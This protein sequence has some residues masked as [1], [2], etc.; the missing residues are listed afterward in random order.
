[1]QYHAGDEEDRKEAKVK[2]MFSKR[3]V[4]SDELNIAF[5]HFSLKGSIRL[6]N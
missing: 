4:L 6:I 1:L 3:Q 5:C 2:V